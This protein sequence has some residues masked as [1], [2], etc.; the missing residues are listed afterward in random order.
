MPHQ[1]SRVPPVA[2]ESASNFAENPGS[3]TVALWTDTTK[4]VWTRDGVA[5][6]DLAT[7]PGETSPAPAQPGPLAPWIA[8]YR[9]QVA[10]RETRQASPEDLATLREL[11]YVEK[12]AE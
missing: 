11:G 6:Y 5:R 8:A 10:W 12:G 1:P 2:F 4:L 3:N 7:D 9:S